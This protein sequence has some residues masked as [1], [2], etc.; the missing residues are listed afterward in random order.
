MTSRAKGEEVG[1]IDRYDRYRY[2]VCVGGKMVSA[3]V[4]G[5]IVV[6]G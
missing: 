5:E 1:M 4:G 6:G 2:S 3:C